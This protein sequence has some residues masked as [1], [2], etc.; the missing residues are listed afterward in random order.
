[1]LAGTTSSVLGA[2]ILISI[3]LP[4]FLIAVVV[5]MS[6]YLYAAHFYRASARELKRL[7][8]SDLVSFDSIVL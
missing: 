2:I 1:M 7:G 4:W 3:V 5:I 8:K 6:V